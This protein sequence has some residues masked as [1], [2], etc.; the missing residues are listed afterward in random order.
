MSD[1]DENKN[2]DEEGSEEE[3][4]EEDPD[5]LPKILKPFVQ[6]GEEKLKT[7]MRVAS[8]TE[9]EACYGIVVGKKAIDAAN[10]LITAHKATLSIMVWEAVGRHDEETALKDLQRAIN[11]HEAEMEIE[12]S[13]G[14]SPL[15]V[16]A[17]KDHAEMV[18]MLL[19]HDVD[20]DKADKWGQTPLIECCKHG[21]L[22]CTKLFWNQMRTRMR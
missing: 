13:M 3:E 11:P 18:R 9:G 12:D 10:K 4:E 17:S 20:P 14:R 1:E 5:K 19:D 22:E 21:A 6:A 15:F 2:S 7:A 8:Y 16:S